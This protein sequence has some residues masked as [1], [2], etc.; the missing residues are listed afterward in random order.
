MSIK[1]DREFR[2]LQAIGRIVRKALDAMAA[3]VR[4]GVTTAELDHIGSRVP[5]RK[6]RIPPRP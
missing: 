6:A 5:F 2:H 4:P 1:S 3:A